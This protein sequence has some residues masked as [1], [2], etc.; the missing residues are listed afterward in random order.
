MIGKVCGRNVCEWRCKR[1]DGPHP[2]NNTLSIVLVTS[3][4]VFCSISG[5]GPDFDR[6]GFDVDRTKKELSLF[7]CPIVSFGTSPC[8]RGILRIPEVSSVLRY[9]PAFTAD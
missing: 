1:H 8:L 3:P 6:V 4:P 5:F 9:I 2:L 7:F